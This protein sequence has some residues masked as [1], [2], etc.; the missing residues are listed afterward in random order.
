MP[1]ESYPAR[2]RKNILDSD[3]TLIISHGPLTGGSKYT[4]ELALKHSR[5][6]LHIDLN[7]NNS[8]KSAQEIY[9][10]INKYN[11]ETLNVAG[12][13]ESKDQYIYQATILLLTTVFHMQLIKTSMPE[14]FIFTPFLPQ[15]VDHAVDIIIKDMTLFD[16]T[17]IARMEEHELV[18]LHQSLGS[19][20]RN[21]FGLCSGNQALLLDCRNKLTKNNI[22]DDE[23]SS[24]II[25]EVWK[26]L[27]ETHVLRIVK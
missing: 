21:T 4:K 6:Y 15:T 11:I 24:F 17:S 25:K 26:Q 18:D 16:K 3:G 14:S 10:W 7:K 27:R 9:N 13:R 1:T 2:I 5:P 23:A 8:F 19:Y 22:H 12:S 20:I